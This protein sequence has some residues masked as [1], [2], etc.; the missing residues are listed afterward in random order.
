MLYSRY[1][2]YLIHLQYLE[3]V[4]RRLIADYNIFY[5]CIVTDDRFHKKLQILQSGKPDHPLLYHLTERELHEQKKYDTAY[6][7]LKLDYDSFVIFARILMDKVA[8]LVMCLLNFSS[9]KHKKPNPEEDF[10]QHKAFF[11]RPENC[12]FTPNEQYAK[13]I[14]EQT[15]WY[16]RSNIKPCP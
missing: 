1:D 9:S 11:L 12:P 15:T 8:K 16:D 2:D 7:T 13:M 3:I 4:W 5:E 10:S 14:R 6:K